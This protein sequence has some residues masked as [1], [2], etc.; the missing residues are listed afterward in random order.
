MFQELRVP[1]RG[2]DLRLSA[3]VAGGTPAKTI[4][5]LARRECQSAFQKLLETHGFERVEL[6]LVMPLELFRSALDGSLLLPSGPQFRDPEGVDWACRSDMTAFSAQVARTRLAR[7]TSCPLRLGYSGEVLSYDNRNALPSSVGLGGRPWSAPAEGRGHGLQHP[8]L[9]SH[10]FGAE[11]IGDIGEADEL[12]TIELAMQ[13]ARDFGYHSCLLVIGHTAVARALLSFADRTGADRRNLLEDVAHCDELRLLARKG[14]QEAI[15][16]GSATA[17]LERLA[18]KLQER[19]GAAD[20]HVVVDPLLIRPQGFYS[21]LTFEIHARYVDESSGRSRLVRVGAGGRYDDLFR[22]YGIKVAACGFK[23]C[24]PSIIGAELRHRCVPY[25]QAAGSSRPGP[26]S[27]AAPRP[28]HRE[29][30]LRIAIPKGRLMERALHAFACL[31]IRPAA[32]PS[33]SRQ[34]VIA[35]QCGGYEFLIVKNADV[36]AFV[37]NAT[38]DAGLVGSDVLEETATGIPRPVTFSFGRTRICLAGSPNQRERVRHAA[39]ARLLI[40][41]KYPRLAARELSRR[42][43]DCEILPLSGSVELASVIGMADAIVDLV[44]TGATLAENGLV[45]FEDLCRTRIHLCVSRGTRYLR[46]ELLKE[47]TATWQSKGLLLTAEDLGP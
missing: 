42:G 26:Q 22:H 13:S 45:V 12:E 21:G 41:S 16:E 23:I 44:E 18:A 46:G 31:N 30:P 10:E 8:Y 17:G 38:A 43:L 15:A 6:P 7:G 20:W 32:D 40:A 27:T 2:A 47:W 11:I 28:G 14:L 19:F 34:L 24:D 25:G 4:D 37:E 5:P 33:T 39:P 9:E 36:A 35:S 1:S 3:T 29:P